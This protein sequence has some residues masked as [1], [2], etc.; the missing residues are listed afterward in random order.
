M[1]KTLH[2]GIVMIGLVMLF[3]CAVGPDYQRPSV[4]VPAAFKEMKGWKEA[5]PRDAGIKAEWWTTFS[6]PL[7]NSLEE[8][9]SISNQSLAQ[10]E[11]QYRQARALVQGARANYFPV[12]S[13][14]AAAKRSWQPT[15]NG[16][17]G[18][19]PTDQ[20]SLSLDAGWEID[21]WGRVRRQVESG[22]ASAQASAADLQALRLS[23]QAELAQNYFQ[24]RTVDAQKKTL[25]DMVIAYQK[26]L[27]LTKNRYATG[28]AAKADVVLAQTQLKSTQA[29]AID[30]GILRAQ[31]EHA[32]A[33][34]TGKAPADFSIPVVPIAPTLPQIPI[35]IPSDILERRPDV[36]SAERKM[37]AA[38]AQIGVA[39]AAYFPSLTL[40]ASTG[41]LSTRLADLLT[42]PSFFWALGP[43][44]LA[45]TLF[46][47]G[48]RKAQTEQAIA[49]YDATVAAYK[50]TVL[51]SFQQVEDNLAAL[52]ILDEETLVQDEAVNSARESVVL[53]TNQYKA[54]IVSY[55]NVITIQSIAL[56][57]ERTALGI[58]GQQLNA[59]ISLIRALGGGWNASELAG[60]EQS[61]GAFPT[62]PPLQQGFN[63]P[64][65]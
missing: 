55:L 4:P 40:S 60:M 57:N 3:G 31:L 63:D 43:A 24:L 50:Q 38:N 49:S 23:I 16:V 21:L 19:N 46:D 62:N 20:Y 51:A 54:G 42:A 47:G 32:I 15:G 2:R 25:D 22:T 11:A 65:N 64:T 14:S 7:L 39:K 44:A 52:R 35:G 58:R 34:L 10:A 9:V 59:A 17:S 29:Q 41:Y 13:T 48:A 1:N 45:Q 37:A 53:T 56:T 27:E 12:I 6:D 8:Q 30:I 36:A 33:L 26:A 61:A 18:T 28:V 5:E